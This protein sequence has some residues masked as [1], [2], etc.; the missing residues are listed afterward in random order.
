M[1]MRSNLPWPLGLALPLLLAACLAPDRVP[2]DAAAPSI[3]LNAIYQ[4]ESNCLVAPEI[5]TQADRPRS[6]FCRDALLD[7]WYVHSRYIAQ[8]RDPN[9]NGPYMSLQL[10]AQDT[11]GKSVDVN[12]VSR[13]AMWTWPPPM[14]TSY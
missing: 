9:M 2:P 1:R 6:C 11:C 8:G 5:R 13:M 12:A 3:D 14:L 10:R 7:V 4:D